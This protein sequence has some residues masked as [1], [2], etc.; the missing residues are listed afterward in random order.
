MVVEVDATSTQEPVPD[1]DDTV[2]ELAETEIHDVLRNER[3]RLVLER[4]TNNDGPAS[5]RELAEHVAAMEIGE[6]TAPEN[7]L[8]SVYVSL[9]QTHLPKLDELGIIDY[10]TDN[11]SVSLTERASQVTVYLEVV[12]QYGLSRNELYLGMAVLGILLALASTLNVPG[13]SAIDPGLWAVG[14]LLLISVTAIYYTVK[15]G[16][17][18]LDRL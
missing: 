10:D 9:H 4:L 15:Q 3:R 8:Q 12:P 11:K 18:V 6:E 5:V 1:D 14:G 16:E 13:F 17:T 7:R 2:E